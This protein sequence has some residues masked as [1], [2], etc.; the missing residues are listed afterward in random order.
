MRRATVLAAILLAVSGCGSSHHALPRPKPVTAARTAASTPPRPHGP[1][2]AILPAA[3][4]GGLGAWTPF[5]S[6]HGVP[7]GWIERVPAHGEAGVAVT[8]LRFDQ[9]L[10]HLTLHAGNE[11]PG[12]HGWRYGDAV[13]GVEQHALIA[14]FNSGFRPSYGAGGFE[15]YGRVGWRLQRGVASVVMY[16]DGSADI[17]VWR[18]RVPAAGRK[19]VAV[20]Q[21]LGLLVANG[22]PPPTV[23]TCI[24]ACWGD[25]LH[26]Q[27]NVA[28]SALG[29]TRA[30]ELV[31]A[32]GETLSV[33]ALADALVA[34]GVVRAM[35]LD[36]N[37]AWVA[38]YAYRHGS[39]G[40]EPQPLIPGQKGIPGDLLQGYYRDFFTVLAAG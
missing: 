37:P 35:E 21:N 25:P 26:E 14:A 3:F 6:V 8:L 36:I 2:V 1:L 12:G 30:G 29:I 27:P 18:G 31:Y 38:A 22:R 9:R 32:A 28:R 11:D 20:R 4:H 40:P 13:G 5:V 24:K 33:R 34:A 23:D 19:V 7:A 17:G 39:T 16:S 15:S 10:A